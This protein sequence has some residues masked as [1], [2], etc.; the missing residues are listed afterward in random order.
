[1]EQDDSE[2]SQRV[3]ANRGITRLSGVAQADDNVL[4]ASN[5]RR[6][7]DIFLAA[8]RLTRMAMVLSDPNQADNPMIFCNPAFLEQTGYSEHEIIGRNCRL[9][10]GAGTDVATVQRI[11]ESLAARQGISTEI[12]NYRRDGRGFWNA[13][14]ISPIFDQGGKLLYYFGSQVDITAHKEAATHHRHHLDAIGAMASGIAH[15]FNNLMTV[16]VASIDQAA[17]EAIS[18]RQRVQLTRAEEAAR[19]AGR[20]TQQMLSFAQRQ[21]LQ[22]QPTDLNQLVAG[23]DDLVRQ[24]VAGNVV[25]D[26]ELAPRP[27]VA[28]LDASQLDLAFVALLRNA[29]DA[30]PPGG[31]VV[32]T[33]R[34]YTAWDRA[35]G[36]AGRGWVELAIADQGAGMTP[37]V[38]R[39][40]TEPFFST[41]PGGAGL[42]L[43]MVQGFV[44]QSGGRLSIE[45]LAGKGTIVRMAFPK[46]VG[47]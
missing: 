29:A 38:A 9:L 10:Q 24:S 23:L 32:V 36:H 40:A 39:R 5:E 30:A 33:T 13:L 1:M 44:E 25:V 19:G 46:L 34:E 11:R 18:E 37:E 17:R 26:F 8:V 14:Y 43:P 47:G 16:T 27:I 15:T 45:T 6:Q 4:P 3:A 22:E 12:F 7:G 28:K 41:K 21:Y 31:R 2:D 42:G 35:D 20:L